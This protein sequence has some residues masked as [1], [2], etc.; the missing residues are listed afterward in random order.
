SIQCIKRPPSK[1]FSGLASLGRTISA[2]SDCESCTGRG[3]SGLLVA[4]MLGTADRFAAARRGTLRQPRLEGALRLP[5]HTGIGMV[6]GPGLS[7]E[8]E[9]QICLRHRGMPQLRTMKDVYF[10]ARLRHAEP[11]GVGVA[12]RRQLWATRRIT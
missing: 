2:I 6:C 9:S 4:V 3:A 5:L 10:R 1:A 11:I 8:I 7:R 12:I